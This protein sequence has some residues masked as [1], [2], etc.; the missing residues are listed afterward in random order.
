MF[1]IFFLKI[2]T[3]SRFRHEMMWILLPIVKMEYYHGGHQRAFY[4][5]LFLLLVAVLPIQAIGKFMK[6]KLIVI[7]N[8]EIV[9]MIT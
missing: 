3:F 6:K 5:F 2:S 7:D 1:S 4:H 8:I 9:Q